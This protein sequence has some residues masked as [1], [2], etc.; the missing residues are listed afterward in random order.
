MSNGPVMYWRTSVPFSEIEAKLK[1]AGRPVGQLLS[2]E[3]VSRTPSFRVGRL[4]FT[5][6]AGDAVIAAKDFRVWLGGD[7][8]KSTAFSVEC[9][10]DTAVFK[11]K[12]WG[13]GVGLC[14]WGALGQSLL[15]KHHEEILNFYYPG[16]Q[17]TDVH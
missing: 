2:I 12:G 17:I 11:G 16:S 9:R 7:R 1:A 5:G 13:H 10:D 4:Q 8:I 15:G 3:A 6:N 14:Q